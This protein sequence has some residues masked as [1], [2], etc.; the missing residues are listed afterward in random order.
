MQCI[1]VITKSKFL[2]RDYDRYGISILKKN[3]NV[4]IIDL[5][6]ITSKRSSE[7]YKFLKLKNVTQPSNLLELFILLK[8]KNILS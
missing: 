1:A 6:I 2:K 4:D 5:S 3:F 8:K 7:F